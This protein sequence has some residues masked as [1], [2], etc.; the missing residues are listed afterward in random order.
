MVLC[1]WKNVIYY[2]RHDDFSQGLYTKSTAK[3]SYECFECEYSTY[4]GFFNIFIH[5]YYLIQ[6][7]RLGSAYCVTKRVLATL[8]L[9]VLLS[10]KLIGLLTTK[11]SVGC[12]ANAPRTTLSV[13]CAHFIER[14]IF[15]SLFFIQM[16]FLYRLLMDNCECIRKHLVG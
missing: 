3:L 12:I 4:I 7:R 8:C 11:F 1:L 6:N 9:H 13:L 10:S 14:S 16:K 2:A 15:R 5:E